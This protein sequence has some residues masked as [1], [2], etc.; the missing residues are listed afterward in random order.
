MARPGRPKAALAL[1][2]VERAELDRLARDGSRRRLA[3][4]ARIV[5]ACASGADNLEVAARLGVSTA[6]V[7]KWRA[8][9][10]TE[11]LEGL[12]DRPRPGRPRQLD[13][14]HLA[15]IVL[16]ANRRR[17]PDGAPRWTTRG[18]AAATGVSQSTVSRLWR[19]HGV[20]PQV[21]APARVPHVPATQAAPTMPA[22]PAH[23]AGLARAVDTAGAKIADSLGSRPRGKKLLAG[24]DKIRHRGG[25]RGRPGSGS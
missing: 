19:K 3:S 25:P 13:D 24:M 1:G 2:D 18:M 9:F 10:V 5:L 6:T 17:P 22:T 7:G 14:D 15:R 20:R 12:A 8:R 4:R 11:R 23:P 21:S 16:D